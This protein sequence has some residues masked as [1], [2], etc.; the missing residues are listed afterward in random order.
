L[1]LTWPR[2]LPRRARYAHRSTRLVVQEH[3]VKVYQILFLIWGIV[4]AFWLVKQFSDSNKRN[5][6]K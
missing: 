2:N 4:F 3:S 1:H 6:D 5:D